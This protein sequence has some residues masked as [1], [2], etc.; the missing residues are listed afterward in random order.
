M[1]LCDK[2]TCKYHS[3]RGCVC[4]SCQSLADVSIPDVFYTWEGALANCSV[5]VCVC[6]ALLL[7]RDMVSSSLPGYPPHI[8][9]G[10]SSYSSSAITGMVAGKHCLSHCTCCFH[11]Y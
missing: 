3:V 11:I 9:S 1:S 2:M 6:V 5:C 8:P 7:G 10:Q 4:T